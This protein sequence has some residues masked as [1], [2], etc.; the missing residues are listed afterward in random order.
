MS[1]VIDV[2][3]KENNESELFLPAYSQIIDKMVPVTGNNILNKINRILRT[4]SNVALRYRKC[5]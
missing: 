3:T 2:N 5:R 1:H 4:L